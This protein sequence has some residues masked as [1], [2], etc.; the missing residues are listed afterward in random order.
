ML[1]SY[2]CGQY[3]SNIMPVIAR[4]YQLSCLCMGVAPLYY[5]T[6]NIIQV[7]NTRRQISC[8]CMCIVP[9][10]YNADNSQDITQRYYLLV[11]DTR[12]HMASRS[13]VIYHLYNNL[14]LFAKYGVKRPNQKTNFRVQILVSVIFSGEIGPRSL[15]RPKNT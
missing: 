5:N 14:R 8:L 13:K 7:Y 6:G 9:L 1:M 12:G 4:I 11:Y 3:P 10:Q 2:V 15:C